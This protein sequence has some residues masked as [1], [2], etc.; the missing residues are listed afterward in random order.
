MKI[1]RFKSKD[2]TRIGYLSDQK[3]I[4]FPSKFGNDIINLI[5]EWDGVPS[6]IDFKTSRRPKKKKDIPHY[7]A[8]G[9]G[10]AVMW[11]ERTGMPI[12]NVVI[13]MDVDN[14][15][16]IVYK[17]H[18]DNHIELLMDTKK[19]YDRRNIFK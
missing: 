13:L 6:I 12:T 4:P 7:F 8:Q 15:H 1:L 18:R 17:E 19:E 11:E 3:I 14:F 2:E 5:A 10:Y 9:A 16:P